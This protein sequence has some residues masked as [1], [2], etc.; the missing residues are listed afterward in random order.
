MA[1]LDYT[2][3]LRPTVL[4]EAAK[5]TTPA[6]ALRL[7]R[8]FGGR[9]LYFPVKIAMSHPIA[10]CV[11]FKAAERLCREWGGEERIVPS[12]RTHLRWLDARGLRLLGLKNDEI[13]QRLRIGERHVRHLLRDFDPDDYVV[14]DTVRSIAL[15]YRVQPSALQA[16]TPVMVP[17]QR[18]FGWPPAPSGMRFTLA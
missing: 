10:R 18:D 12:A 16:R 9:K 2:H 15:L 8:E 13:A 11:G 14:D 4:A 7:A 3:A 1:R 17:L 6:L 5:L